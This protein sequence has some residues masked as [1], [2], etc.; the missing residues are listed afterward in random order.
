MNSKI[1]SKTTHRTTPKPT[2]E[3][4]ATGASVEDFINAV[5]DDT[6]RADCQVL[7]Q[8]M[9]RATGEPPR[10]WGSS[11]VGF[12]SYRSKTGVW[13]L[14]GFSPRKNDL[15]LYVMPGLDDLQPLLARLGKHKTGQS[16]LY[17]KRMGDVDASVLAQIVQA[18]VESRSAQRVRA[19]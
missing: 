16:C 18:G 6:R 3:T 1:A 13:P 19:A 9:H 15:T 7:V 17:L 2:P 14:I 4:T 12:A 10:M 5:P 8:L 11:I